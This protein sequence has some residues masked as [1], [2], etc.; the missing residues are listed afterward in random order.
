MLNVFRIAVVITLIG[1]ALAYMFYPS[2]THR[3]SV[4]SLK[5]GDSITTI[6]GNGHA[7]LYVFESVDCVFCRKLQ[8]E[9]DKIADVTIYTF[10][11]PGHSPEATVTG[12]AVW[13]SSDPRD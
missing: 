4:R 9:L 12:R 10:L 2:E 11:L 7:R 1:A 8:P 6:H 13:C 3:I 5:L